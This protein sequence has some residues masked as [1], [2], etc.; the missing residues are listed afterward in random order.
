[1][2]K[3]YF[4]LFCHL[5]SNEGDSLQ[6]LL[7]WLSI[8]VNPN[9][10]NITTLTLIGKPGAGKGLL[11]EEVLKPLVG[12]KNAVL[13]RGGDSTNSRFNG[14]YLNRR[15]IM[16]DEVKLK[17][18]EA[19]DRFKT[20]AN[21]T[22]EIE[23]KGKDPIYTKNWANTIVTSNNLD[24]IYIEPGDRRF[25]IVQLTD[26]NLENMIIDDGYKDIDGYLASLRQ[27]GLINTL[28]NWLSEHKPD[29]NMNIPFR[30][31]TK[32]ADIKSASFVEWERALIEFFNQNIG[33]KFWLSD[34]Q[35]KLTLEYNVKHPPGRTKIKRLFET[36]G[37]CYKMKQDN[38]TGRYF[39]EVDG[40][41]ILPTSDEKGDM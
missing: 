7:D 19:I 17:D 15:L 24:S 29:R 18:P 3:P 9:S 6:Y 30:A 5:T 13:V 2:P 35:D 39:V 36:T 16:L 38:K 8:L 10:R 25:S 32:T 28:Y 40:S 41:Y 1:M 11:F 22:I 34:V 21:P 20:F 27:D 37:N 12:S 26:N 31:E 23:Q 33:N 14:S 4:D